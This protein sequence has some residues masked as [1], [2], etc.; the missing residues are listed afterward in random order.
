MSANLC[1][2]CEKDVMVCT[3]KRAIKC[4]TN[5]PSFFANL[6]QGSDLPNKF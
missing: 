4:M 2:S 1:I 6:V 3:F 5:I